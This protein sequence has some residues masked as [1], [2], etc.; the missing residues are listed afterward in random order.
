MNI[1]IYI[2]MLLIFESHIEYDSHS[3]TYLQ[4]RSSIIRCVLSDSLGALHGPH[5][6]D[7]H[8]V[9]ASTCSRPSTA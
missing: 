2:I 5:Q 8:D 1:D 3:H 9:W 7:H 6:H 4:S